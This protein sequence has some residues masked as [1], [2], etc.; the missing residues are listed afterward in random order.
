M[1]DVASLLAQ[2]DEIA[3][4][5]ARR[6]DDQLA[7]KARAV[8]ADLRAATAPP[9]LISV[10]E[11]AKILDISSTGMVMRWARERRLEGF[12]VKGRVKVSRRSVEKLIGSPLVKR[13]QE[14]ERELDEI[15]EAFDAGDIELPPSYASSHG[16]APWDSVAAQQ[17]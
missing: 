17:A 11:A 8:A 2:L 16:R 12:N 15:L 3:D 13:E 9:E 4:E 6:G 14:Y 10:E 1:A 5:L 7:E